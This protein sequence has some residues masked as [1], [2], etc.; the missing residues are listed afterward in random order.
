M[1]LVSER[2]RNSFFPLSENQKR[3]RRRFANGLV[4]REW[5]C[6]KGWRPRGPACAL[7]SC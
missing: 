5:F 7:T 3:D 2:E 4:V 1:K 6:L